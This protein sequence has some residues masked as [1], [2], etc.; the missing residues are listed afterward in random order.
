VFF[1]S[2]QTG[3]SFGEF[4]A[5]RPFYRHKTRSAPGRNDKT[6]AA[7]GFFLVAAKSARK[8]FAACQGRMRSACFVTKLR[9]KVLNYPGAP[10]RRNA[11][12][13]AEL[14]GAQKAPRDGLAV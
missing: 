11:S 12:F 8:G 1:F 14:A 9:Y 5:V 7:S 3:Y 6:E 13:D 10:G 4:Q 2:C